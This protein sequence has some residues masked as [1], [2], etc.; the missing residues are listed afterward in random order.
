ME[1]AKPPLFSGKIEEMGVFIN[2]A[3][4]YLRMK[5]GRRGQ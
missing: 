5:S 1:M 2:A 3:H 4:L